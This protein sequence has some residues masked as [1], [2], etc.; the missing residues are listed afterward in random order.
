MAKRK[1]G[2]SIKLVVIAMLTVG[3]TNVVSS[4]L[5]TLAMSVSKADSRYQTTMTTTNQAGQ[6][7]QR[8]L[9]TGKHIDHVSNS[10]GFVQVFPNRR[11]QT[12]TGV[13]GALTDSAASV[14]QKSRPQTRRQILT[15]YFG[16]Q[17]ARYTNLRLTIGSADFSTFGYTYAKQAGPAA[18]SL[19]PDDVHVSPV[20]QQ[21]LKQAPNVQIM[22]A[23]WA[24][25]KW[26]KVSHRRDG[27]NFL[28]NNALKRSAMPAYA[29]YLVEYVDAQQ[30]RGVAIKT[31]SLQNELQ[32]SSPWEA[33]TWTPDAAAT[34][35]THYLGPK[36]KARHP[37]TKIMVWDYVK[38]DATQPIMMGFNQ[39]TQKFYAHRGMH[40]YVDSVGVHWYAAS[41]NAQMSL[42][43]LSGQP[44]WDDNFNNLDQFHR[45]QP[46]QQ[47]IA[48][49]AAQ[50][51]GVW[52]N[53]WTPAARY[54]YDIINDFEHH[55]QGYLDWNLVL[56][57]QGGPTHAAVNPCGAA[58]NVLHAGSPK[59]QLVINPAYYVLKRVSRD[60]QPGTVSVASTTNRQLDHTA[61]LQHD[62]STQLLLENRS[63]H[64]QAVQ[65]VIGH[66][67]YKVRLT[68]H[69]FN[70]LQLP[71][72][73][74]KNLKTPP[75]THTPTSLKRLSRFD[76][77][78]V[79]PI[80]RFLGLQD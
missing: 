70:S 15:A 39:W 63:S 21:I 11:R 56:N 28:V 41:L 32:A 4:T 29:D 31:L 6:H 10:T 23:P 50:E 3:V 19:K 71:K 37:Q 49:E 12:F 38:S 22:A 65:A 52:L 46:Q 64:V 77:H 5:P 75:I 60:V 80:Y 57:G 7:D 35:I 62:G 16:A 59:E 48:T 79:T 44:A 36:L 73:T 40:Q 66:R 69:S 30:R 74:A 78:W 34:F 68:P 45:Q 9:V 33:M 26:M 67:A 2:S 58:I 25:P 20:L 54:G 8:H 55:V 53:Q 76:N 42:G 61:I 24:P 13:G 17:G 43:N 47:I 51:K 18:F 1:L 14:I 72:Q 27:Q